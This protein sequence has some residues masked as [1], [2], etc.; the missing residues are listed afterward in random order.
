MK[1]TSS[2]RRRFLQSS[3]AAVLAAP[4]VAQ[5]VHAD[6]DDLLKVGLI[7]CGGR[8]TGAAAQALHADRNVKLWAMGDAFRDKLE[9]SLGILRRDRTLEGKIDVPAERCFAGFNAYQQVIG[10]GVDVVLLCTPPHFRPLHL[11]A[12]VQANKHVFAE[13]PVAVDAPGVRA[14][15]ATCAEA[16]RRNLSIVSGLCLRYSNAYREMIRRIHDGAIGDIKSLQAND[17]RGRIWVFPR[18]EAWSD[19]EWQMRNWYYFTWL[20]G[21]FNVEQHVHN[22]DVCT[23]ALRDQMPARCTGMGGRQVRTGPEFGN[24]YDHFAVVYEYQ[25]GVKVFSNTRQ[26][27]N[28]QNDIT[29]FALGSRGNAEISE[30]RQVIT[31]QSPWSTRG[32]DNDFYQTEHDKLFAGI[33]SGRPINN[34]EY[35]SRST[36]MAIMG[37]MAAYTGRTITWEM[38]LNSREDLTPARYE[39]GRLETPA[40]A[41]PGV[42]RFQ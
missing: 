9:T 31:G 35:M 11:R 37:R 14:V 13:K 24:I 22:L 23:W 2:T 20:S 17:L 27:V 42:T 28:C 34:G 7:G 4:L 21:D 29:V 18:Q 40:V 32:P 30:R 8:G 19:M 3:T 39:W 26:Q 36:L 15:L 25:S 12:A 6:G 16:R 10:S 41:M 38:A 33:R 1:K 5:G